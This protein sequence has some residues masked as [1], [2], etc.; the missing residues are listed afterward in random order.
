MELI[1]SQEGSGR[2]LLESDTLSIF[3]TMTF[4]PYHLYLD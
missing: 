4:P 2:M 3:G 1:N